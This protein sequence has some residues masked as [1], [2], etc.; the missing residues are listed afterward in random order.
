MDAALKKA[1]SHLFRLDWLLRKRFA[2]GVLHQRLEFNLRVKTSGSASSAA[3]G[4]RAA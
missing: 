2:I 3:T 1:L 4:F